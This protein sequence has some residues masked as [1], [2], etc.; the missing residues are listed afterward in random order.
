[1]SEQNYWGRLNRKRL[2]RRS[3]LSAS[4]KAGVG[5]AGLALV[6]CGDDDDDDEAVTQAPAGDTA[7]QAADQTTDQAADD[8]DDQV[9]PA[10]DADDAADQAVATGPQR[11]GSIRTYDNGD[12]ASFDGFLTFGYRAFLHGK[13]TYPMLEKFEVG[14]GLGALDFPP[15]LE[16]G[17]TYELV[18]ELTHTYTIK[19]NANWEDEP[20]TGGRAVTSEDVAFSFSGERYANYPNRGIILPHLDSM[21][22]PDAKT[23]TFNLNKPVAP[24]RLY[25]G[26]HAGPYTMP[27]EA[28]EAENTRQNMISAG[29]FSL[30]S[31]NAGASVTYVRNDSYHGE[32]TYVDSVEMVFLS[33]DSAIQAAIRTGELQL[34]VRPNMPN[35]IALDLKD[36]LPDAKFTTF[37]DNVIGGIFFDLAIWTDPRARQALGNAFDR[38]GWLAVSDSLGKGGGWGSSLPALPPFAIDSEPE[39]SVLHDFFKLDLQR[40]RQ[41]LDAAGIEDGFDA[42][43]IAVPAANTYGTTFTEGGLLIQANLQAI[44]LNID[45]ELRDS[46]E[47]YATTFRGTGNDGNFGITT[48]VQ[49]IEADE[50]F[51]NMYRGDSPR[52]PIINGELMFDDQ[53]LTDLIDG[54][55]AA[56]TVEER[57]EVIRDLQIHLAENMY[58]VPLA[59]AARNLYAAPELILKGTPKAS[60]TGTET[61]ATA[62]FANV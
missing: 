21:D 60:F 55:L 57:I 45:A 17:A 35:T 56:P 58:M 61:M 46:T 49:G 51:V 53:R 40:A 52:S 2:T 15:T 19:D 47:H 43:S 9:A 14:E 50:L 29:P 30:G 54:Q 62:A 25:M 39:D 10:D 13:Q 44:G 6:G 42:G 20:L 5:A 22:T 34:G 11:G 12:I 1:M 26:H 37:S 27:P 8:A 59:Y 33:D 28:V 18:D 3:M 32:P 38:N 23:I 7:D 16:L 31:Y 48:S 36:D 41:L 24:F 4:A